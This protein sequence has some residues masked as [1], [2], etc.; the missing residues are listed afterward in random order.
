MPIKH[1]KVSTEPEGP[2]PDQINASDWN[3][4]HDLSA[5]T[6]ADFPTAMRPT[7]GNLILPG[8]AS[9]SASAYAVKGTIYRADT[10]IT[11]TH[12]RAFQAATFSGTYSHGVALLLSKTESPA[13]TI[14][15]ATFDAPLAEAT[16]VAWPA[17]NGFR[18]A[19]LPTP[20][21]IAAGTDFF[22]YVSI[23]SGT[24]TSIARV[25]SGANGAFFSGALTPYIGTPQIA[26]NPFVGGAPGTIG[27][28][29]YNVSPVCYP[30]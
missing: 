13:G 22:V 28:G 2:D 1:L 20:V 12:V 19:A 11:I 30:R 5:L 15:A 18:E 3:A 4:A 25:Q 23:T 10:D 26:Q 7:W 17:A 9:T 8:S 24:N 21:N 6:W 29:I 14:T 16:G 27:T